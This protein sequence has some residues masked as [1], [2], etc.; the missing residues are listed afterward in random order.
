MGKTTQR[1]RSSNVCIKNKK[2]FFDYERLD[3]YTAGLVLQGTEVK[4]IRMGKV[5]LKDAFCFFQDNE[6]WVRGMHISHY[7]EGGID[8]HAPTR[9]RKVL[10]HKRELR[11]LQKAKAEKGLTIIPVTLFTNTHGLIKMDIALGRG[12]KSHDK[13]RTL[14]ERDLAREQA[15]T[16][17][18]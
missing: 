10:L 14:K 4:A 5:N 13:R 2:A 11:K 12:K 15:G 17:H 6:L 9:R 16:T 8:N 7:Q 3:T 18:H 1:P